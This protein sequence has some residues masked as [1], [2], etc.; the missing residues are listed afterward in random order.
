MPLIPDLVL[1]LTLHSVIACASVEGVIR[2][3]AVR[4]PATRIALRDLAL[5]LPL[6]FLPVAAWLAPWRTGEH[7]LA[8]ALFVSQ[9]FDRIMIGDLPLRQAAWWAC[10]AV[11]AVLLLRDARVRLHRP[12]ARPIEAPDLASHAALVASTRAVVERLSE[13]VGVTPPVVRVVESDRPLMHLEGAK[14]RHMVF[15]TATLARLETAQL[16][17]A[18][19][20]ELAHLVNR[21]LRRSVVMLPVRL[22]LIASPLAHVTARRQHQELEW[23]AD[24]V[25]ARVTGQPIALARALVAS[26][27]AASGDYLGLLGQGRLEALERR[28]YRLA[29]H[30]HLLTEPHRLPLALTA[31]GLLATMCLVS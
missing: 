30:E 6:V 10:A 20:H 17:A 15:S 25:A 29:D 21:D 23:R 1:G 16:E 24:D 11:G 4:A 14:R 13:R 7:F 28:C 31:I 27:K 8:Q 3:L 9:R 12:H 5:L 19:A 18:I 22:A 2:A 26:G